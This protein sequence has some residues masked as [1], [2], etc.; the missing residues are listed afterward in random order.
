MHKYRPIN[1]GRPINQATNLS[2]LQP[3]GGKMEI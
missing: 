3:T 2:T 1:K